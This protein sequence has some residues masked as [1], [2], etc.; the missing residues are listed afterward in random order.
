MYRYICFVGVLFKIQWN[1][2][3]IYIC[4]S[5]QRISFTCVVFSLL[6]FLWLCRSSFLVQPSCHH[7]HRPA[8]STFLFGNCSFISPLPA[9][10][11]SS[12]WHQAA[13]SKHSTYNDNNNA[14][15]RR[16]C[17]IFAILPEIWEGNA[18]IV[19]N[20][21]Q[22]QQQQNMHKVVKNMRTSC[23]CW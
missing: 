2:S 12:T 5:W 6:L 7:I 8:H 19:Y 10:A 3:W 22:Q 14:G 1:F 21:Q 4:H 13:F 9:L 17:Y 11:I 18:C 16:D 23:Q 20:T 15:E